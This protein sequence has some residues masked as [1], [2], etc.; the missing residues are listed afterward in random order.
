MTFGKLN[1][2]FYKI[3]NNYSNMTSMCRGKATLEKVS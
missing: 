1:K 2:S 3:H